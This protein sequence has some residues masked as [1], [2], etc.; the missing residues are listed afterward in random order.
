M[1]FGLTSRTKE[2]VIVRFTL[3]LGAIYIRLA[4]VIEN[5]NRLSMSK[6]L[7]QSKKPNAAIHSAISNAP[8]QKN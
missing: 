3:L 8:Q 7:H 5:Q 6:S 2:R 1:P 4:A